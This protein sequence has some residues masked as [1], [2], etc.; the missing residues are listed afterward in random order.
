M[1][2]KSKTKREQLELELNN[3]KKSVKETFIK[4][5]ENGK[6]IGGIHEIY[7]SVKPYEAKGAINQAW[8]IAEIFRIILD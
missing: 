5:L 6:T 3:F 2:E 8:S 7:D 4:E 1:K